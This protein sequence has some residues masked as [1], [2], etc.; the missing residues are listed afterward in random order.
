MIVLDTHVWIWL[1][2]G[3]KLLSARAKK[4]IKGAKR[5]GLAAISVWEFSMLLSKGRISSDRDPL[6]WVEQSFEELI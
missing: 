5:V 1:V 4:E 2:D 6:E 3:S